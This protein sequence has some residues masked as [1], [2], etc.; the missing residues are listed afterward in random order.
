[1]TDFQPLAGFYLHKMGTKRRVHADRATADAEAQRLADANGET[2]V[3]T[4]EVGRVTA[5]AARG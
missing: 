3:V 2:F 1:M 4:Q 5:R